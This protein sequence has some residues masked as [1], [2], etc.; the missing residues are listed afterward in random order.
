MPSTIVTDKAKEVFGSLQQ[1][2]QGHA[3]DKAERIWSISSHCH[4]NHGFQFNSQSTAMQYTKQKTI[5]GRAWA[6]IKLTN[7]PQEK[8]LVLWANSSLGLLLHW[9][10]ANKQQA[11]RGNIGVS[12]LESLPVLDVTKLSE[13]QLNIAVVIFDDMKRKELR[14]INEIANDA[15]RAELDTRLATEVLGFPPELVAEDGPLAL[16]KQKLG[17]EPSINGGKKSKSVYMGN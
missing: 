12:A 3:K 17:L 13:E 9:W 10:H 5:G 1:Q 16:L 7:E 2:L 14:P 8:A 11:G 4:F 15:V 6:S